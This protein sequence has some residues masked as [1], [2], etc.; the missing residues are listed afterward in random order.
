MLV[1]LIGNRRILLNFS[2]KRF[3]DM[4]FCFYLF[5]LLFNSLLQIKDKGTLFVYLR[6]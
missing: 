5:V 1:S 3:N 4:V 6:P 2:D